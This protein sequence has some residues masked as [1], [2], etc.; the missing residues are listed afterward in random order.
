MVEVRVKRPAITSFVDKNYLF[1]ALVALLFTQNTPAETSGLLLGTFEKEFQEVDKKNLQIVFSK[2]G[3]NLRILEIS[4]QSLIDEIGQIDNSQHFGYAAFGRLALQNQIRER[5][6]YSDV[7]VLFHLDA[8]ELIDKL[9]NS[10]QLGFVR[11]AEAFALAD[12]NCPAENNEFFA[13]FI[14]WPEITLRPNLSFDPPQTWKTPYSSHDQ[15]LLN[16]RIGQNYE[17]LD[18]HLCQLDNPLL[19]ASNYK[20]G[21]VHYFGNWKPWQATGLSRKR[22]WSNN[23]SWTLWFK[24][25]EE[26][27]KLL[28]SLGLGSWFREL[29]RASL[30]GAPKNL[31]TLR[32]I[33]W[34]GRLTG[35]FSIVE[36][37]V[38]SLWKGEKHLIH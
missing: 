26:A 6:I 34:V 27:E 21:I 17:R 24:A 1:P 37:L 9:P 5:H 10:K 18:P 14:V 19:D 8:G 12:L 11:Q 15:A 4:K 16:M 28:S 36:W 7:D 25:E 38:R 32:R 30:R 33:V 23:C 13:G 31:K 29:R 35:T 3:M 20:P 2:T 22:C